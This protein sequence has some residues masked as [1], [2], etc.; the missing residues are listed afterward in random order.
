M[1]KP[2]KHQGVYLD[3]TAETYGFVVDG[4][5][6]GQSRKQIRR[7]GFERASDA[8]DARNEILRSV[9]SRTFA[10][11]AKLTLDELVSADLETQLNLGKLRPSS[12]QTYRR[13][14][15]TH[16]SPKL[17]T[18]RAQDVQGEHLD[19]VYADL[20]AGGLAPAGVRRVHH[21]LSGVYRRALKRKAVT[22][23]PCADATPPAESTEERLIWSLAEQQQFRAHDAVRA[24]DLAPLFDTLA[25]TGL[26]RGEALALGWDDVDLDAG[27]IYVHRNAVLVDGEVKIGP[28]K[29]KR[30]ERR[31]RIGPETV[32]MLRDHLARQ[33]EHRLT[34][35]AGWQDRGLVFPRHDG[36]PR[37]PAAV[38]DA[39]ARLVKR[40]G[41]PPVTLHS[42]R[43]S[44][45][46]AL[47]EQGVPVHSVA[48]RIGDRPDVM[49]RTYAHALAGSQDNA[50]ELGETLLT[51]GRPA[52]RVVGED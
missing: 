40:T 15:R 47:L 13:D 52:L 11:P 42:L 26:R 30:S 38:T 35:G 6:P 2:T 19:K 21:L 48:A 44:H 24:H 23:N 16:V 12:V 45:A 5:A 29:T 43:H 4:A 41:L 14:V 49:L 1:R 34:M 3:T 37:N 9:R 32:A 28:P 10:A 20:L 7:G 33:R 17:G 51:E 22:V 50:A 8:R 39:F 36:T 46:T 31:V 25:V 27:T 18:M